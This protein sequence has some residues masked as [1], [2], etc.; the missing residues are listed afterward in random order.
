[1]KK[2]RLEAKNLK[3]RYKK[4]EVVKG[5]SL[6]VESGSVVGLLGPNGAGKTTTFYMITGFVKRNGGNV[7]YNGE[8]IS[9][10]KMYERGE[11][12]IT[13]LPQE[14]SIFRKLTVYENIMAVLEYRYK[15]KKKRK[16]LAESLMEEFKITY[17]RNNLGLQLSGGETRRVEIARAL[18]SE[19]TFVLL[20]EP[21]TGVDPKSIED[22][23]KMIID[24]KKKNI[25]VLITD[26]NVRETLKIT[27]YSYIIY[28][29]KILTKGDAEKLINDPM[30]KSHYLGE[31]FTI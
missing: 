17:L 9:T 14:K 10:M 31:E 16:E 3:K 15:D 7:F 20:D 12:G 5:I 30:V 29:G 19:P 1:M 2:N 24:L 27:D 18:A 13:Y 26:H 6:E 28:E 22:L 23:Q 11:L 25:G 8:D 21:F 4:R